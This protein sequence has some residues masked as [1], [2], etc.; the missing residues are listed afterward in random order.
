MTMLIADAKFPTATITLLDGHY[1]IAAR[2]VGRLE[3]D[4]RPGLYCVQ[5]RAGRGYLEKYVALSD[6]GPQEV[7][8]NLADAVLPA[9]SPEPQVQ[10]VEHRERF[11]SGAELAA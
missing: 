11:G 5:F 2:G 1:G 9:S 6:S 10:L 4:R 3:V 8:V 7:S